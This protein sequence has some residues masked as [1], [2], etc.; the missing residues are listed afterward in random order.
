MNPRLVRTLMLLITMC[1]IIASPASA[2]RALAAQPQ[3]ERP[4][5]QIA[6]LLDTSN[7]M[8]G[9]I[10]QAKTHLWKV[11]NEFAAARQNGQRPMLQVALYEYGNDSL[12]AGEGYVRLVAPLTDDLDQI[13]QELFALSTNGGSEF[14]GHVIRDS[15][16][17]LQWSSG[18]QDF[19]AIFIA[20]NEPFTQGEIDYAES[21]KSAIVK[22]VI[23]NTIFCGPHQQG[24]DGKWA[25][26]AALADGRYLNIDQDQ[27]IVH[28]PAPQDQ[29]IAQ[30]NSQL[31]RTYLAYG[32]H[33]AEGLGRQV[34]QDEQAEQLDAAV[35]SQRVAAK[36]SSL[37]TNRRWD[38]VDAAKE[39]DFDI[40]KIKEEDLPQDMR[41]I[42]KEQKVARIAEMQKQRDEVNLEIKTLVAEREKYVAEERKKQ[43]QTD[44]ERTFD[45]ALIEVV[46]DQAG[47]NGFEFQ[48]D[49]QVNQPRP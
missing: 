24:V 5:I 18:A 11:V 44:G 23:V 34:A 27:K 14:C 21:C 20:G 8:D 28:I 32:V 17:A 42:S 43:S 15:I 25:D 9:L 36:S 38:L 45:A 26:G 39:S 33:A 35:L 12:S 7:S 6:L 16:N 40:D 49:D 1:L 37:Y 47:R 10:D 30:L 22:G 31:N 19:K 41:G 48:T 3:A 13:S 2:R 46:R 29:R 4:L